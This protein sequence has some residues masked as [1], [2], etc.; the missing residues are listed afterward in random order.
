MFKLMKLEW[1]KHNIKKYI[2]NAAILTALLAVFNFAMV[3]LGIAND[4]ATGVPDMALQHMGVSTNVELLTDISF[5]IFA[6]AMH[7]TF[8]ISA[9][10][11]KTMALMFTYPVSRKKIMLSKMASVW[12]FN[13]IALIA[14]KLI[15]YGVI[16]IGMNFY[17]NPAFPMDVDLL[18][19]L[20]YLTLLLKSASTICISFIALF[21]G[22]AVKSSKA[23]IVASFLL[24][25][26]MQG[27]VGG[28][29]LRNNL[30]MPVILTVISIFFAC[31]CIWKAEK[32]ENKEVITLWVNYRRYQA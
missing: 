30:L 25:V 22:M 9:Y 12:I 18:S 7:A 11:N 15:C 10:K 5:L 32:K 3:F 16:Q 8:I 17:Q 4:S 28:V 13:F 6:A 14:A 29:S 31:I 19:P 24:I 2:R 26:L 21:I 20:F 23:A 1:K 27:N